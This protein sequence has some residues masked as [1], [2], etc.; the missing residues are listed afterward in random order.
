MADRLLTAREVADYYSVPLA[1]LYQWNSKGTGP[2]Y[3]RIG[4]NARYRRA[5]VD[6]WLDAHVDEPK[7][8]A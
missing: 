5:D 7:P 4:R 3:A 1:T 6:A 2:R 8:A